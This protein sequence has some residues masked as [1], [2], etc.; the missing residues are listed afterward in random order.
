MVPNVGEVARVCECNSGGAVANFNRANDVS[1]G[2]LEFAPEHKHVLATL[3]DDELA[4]TS[5]G[6][7]NRHRIVERHIDESVLEGV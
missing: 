2:A 1:R 5:V 6:N 3:V 7:R 4:A